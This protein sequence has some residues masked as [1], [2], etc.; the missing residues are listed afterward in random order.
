MFKFHYCWPEFAFSG[1]LE[2]SPSETY[3]WL[4][5]LLAK[6]GWQEMWGQRRD[7]EGR[8]SR[9]IAV[10]GLVTRIYIQEVIS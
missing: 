10:N 1:R 7:G 9:V 4:A 5:K 8:A 6:L 3:P 2:P